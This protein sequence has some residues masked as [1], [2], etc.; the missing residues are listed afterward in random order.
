QSH[1]AAAEVAAKRDGVNRLIFDFAFALHGAHT[2]SH[3]NRR[4]AACAELGMHP[5]HDPR[6]RHVAGIGDV[7]TAG[8][9]G[10]DGSRTRGFN[11]AAHRRR[12][13]A[14]LTGAMTRRIKL[15]QRD[16]VNAFDLVV[17]NCFSGHDLLLFSYSRTPTQVTKSSSFSSVLDFCAISNIRIQSSMET[18]RPPRPVMIFVTAGRFFS[19]YRADRTSCISIPPSSG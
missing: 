1:I 9:A 19:G 17:N 18:S 12:G 2:C 14:S 5:R 13:F 11:E 4:R 10:D 15:F 16:L 6:G 3:S 8:R 7:H